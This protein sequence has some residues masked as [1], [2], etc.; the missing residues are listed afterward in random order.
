MTPER[1]VVD[2]ALALLER[3]SKD[4]N[5]G[6]PRDAYFPHGML[7]YH[8]ML[9]TKVLR[10]QS[11]LNSK[12]KPNFE[13][14]EDSLEDLLNYTI[15]ALVYVQG[16]NPRTRAGGSGSLSAPMHD[17]SVECNGNSKK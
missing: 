17:S 7:S 1:R 6:V 8:Q 5:S 4:Y 11:L 2:K 10:I 12:S 16:L 13:S 3:K 15:M 14:I 9:H